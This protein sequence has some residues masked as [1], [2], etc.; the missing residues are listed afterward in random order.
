M[1]ALHVFTVPVSRNGIVMF[2]LQRA[3]ALA[4]AG[5]Q[6]DFVSPNPV[7][8]DLLEQIRA[9]GIE[10]VFVL[11]QKR[12][13]VSYVRALARLTRRGRYDIVHAHGN[14]SSL[15]FEMLA[16]FLGGAPTRVA[17]CHNTTCNH[18]RQ[19]AR[20]RP[21]FYHSYTAAAACGR[22]AGKWLFGRRPF[23]VLANAVDVDAFAFDAALR[24]KT[25]RE[26]G[27]EDGW[28]IGHVGRFNGQKNHRFLMQVF[29]QALQRRPEARLLLVGD[30]YLEAQ[31]RDL[32]R[33]FGE[34]VVFTGSVTD[35]RPYLCA[36]D[37][38]ALPSLFEG[39]PTVLLEWQCAGLP[40]LASDRVTRE[41]ALTPLVAFEPLES[42]A[43]AWA[44]RLASLPSAPREAASAQAAAELR[45][46]G[47]ALED[48][49]AA[50]L[51]FY[52]RVARPRRS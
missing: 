16:A 47:Y 6:I 25:R 38:M 18:R 12:P 1:R 24:E 8:P 2:A 21:L 26:L 39:F 41:A 31:I 49:A 32:A 29:S 3:Q 35:P 9:Q 34:R 19:D 20:L 43:Q 40:T 17:H 28:V 36:M 7:E 30:G 44:Q 46:R 5:I 51:A 4:R 10:N 13:G 11:A 52:R 33:P 27:L 22:D 50:L 14:S 15:F 23:W 48:A 37:V 45:R 42:G